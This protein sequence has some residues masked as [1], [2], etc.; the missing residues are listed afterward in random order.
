MMFL[1]IVLDRPGTSR[2]D[3]FLGFKD[4]RTKFTCFTSVS[5]LLISEAHLEP[6]Q[7]CMIKYFCKNLHR[8][9]LKGS[10]YASE[11]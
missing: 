6:C 7:T 5:T 10:K 3:I 4:T 9:S 11:F 1:S 2:G 8:R